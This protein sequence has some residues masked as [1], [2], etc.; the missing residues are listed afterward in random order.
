MRALVTGMMTPVG[1]FVVRRLAE[2]G[3]QVTAAGTASSDFSLHSKAVKRRLVF[4][5]IRYQ[6][7]R[8]ARAV[9]DELASGDYDIYVPTFEDGFVMSYYA[10]E[11][12][13]YARFISMPFESI[14]FVHDKGNMA[15]FGQR[16]GVPPPNPTFVPV[17]R[18]E[19]PA[20]FEAVDCPVV[21]KPR[22]KCNA[23]GQAVLDDPKRLPEVY[24]DLLARQGADDEDLPMIQRRVRGPVL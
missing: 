7:E 10:E 2:M 6:P 8:F 4:P 11:I 12:N 18:A 5:S 22:R 3:F 21:V 23:H 24:A 17:S 19:L 20:I 9:L 13:K 1:L 15:R 14:L 16:I